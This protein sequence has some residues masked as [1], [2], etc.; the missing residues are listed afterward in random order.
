MAADKLVDSTQLDS[1]LTSVA[2]AI[3]IK[4]GTS[5]QMAFPAG[6]VSA[7]QAIP[8]GITPTGTKQISITANGTTTEDVTNYASAEITVNVSGGGGDGYKEK[9]LGLIAR[10]QTTIEDA[11][12]TSIGKSAFRDYASLTSAI[13]AN[14]TSV[15]DGAFYGCSALATLKLPNLTTIVGSSV[16]YSVVAPLVFPKLATYPSINAINGCKASAIDLGP[17]ISNIPSFMFNSSSNLKTLILR[18]TSIADL[19]AI[20]AFNGTPFASN[21]TGGAL[22]VPS[23]LISTYQSATNWSTI[24]GYANNQ[25]LPI[26]GSIYETQYADG[27]PIT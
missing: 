11:D 22:Y 3:R 27:T 2:N 16:F 21:G 4:G 26:E 1:D 15:G 7:V 5:G 12:V 24:L 25:I 6:F 20:N 8:T 19:G 18:K 10:T 14:C 23:A 17:T 9:W 13:F